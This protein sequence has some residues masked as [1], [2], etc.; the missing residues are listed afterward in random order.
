[1]ASF[2]QGVTAVH[3]VWLYGS[4][5]MGRH[6]PGSAIDL[7]LL[8]E[9]PVPLRQHVARVGRPL[10]CNRAPA[11]AGVHLLLIPWLQPLQLSPCPRG[12]VVSPSQPADKM[13]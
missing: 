4:R 7:S 12:V 5:A 2:A 1:M 6:R 9:L 8:H 13:P 11:L 10:C 3:E